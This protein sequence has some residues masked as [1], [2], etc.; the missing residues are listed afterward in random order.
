[1]GHTTGR[2]PKRALPGKRKLDGVPCA[3]RT[4]NIEVGRWSEVLLHTSQIFSD[5]SCSCNV[6]VY[7]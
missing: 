7:R 3:T 4:V 5:A 6:D 1:M 2:R